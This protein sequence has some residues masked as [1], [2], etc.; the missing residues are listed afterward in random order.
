MFDDLA[1][2]QLENIHDGVA[3]A[4]RRRHI[5]NVQDH[6]VAVGEDAFDVAVIVGEFFAEESEKCLQPLRAI[7]SPRIMLDVAWTKKL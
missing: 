2:L 5:V 1:V 6:V 4:A 7:G 3:A